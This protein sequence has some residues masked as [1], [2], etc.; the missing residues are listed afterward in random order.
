[1]YLSFVVA[2]GVGIFAVLSLTILPN[3]KTNVKKQSVT[4]TTIATNP[5][6]LRLGINDD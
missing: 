6:L 5:L 2:D 3:I 4:E 1:M